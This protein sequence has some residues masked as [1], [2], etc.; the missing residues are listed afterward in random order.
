VVLRLKEL[1]PG[2]DGKVTPTIAN[3]VVTGLQFKTDEVD[4]VSPVRALTGLVKLECPGTFLKNGK[5][6]DLTPLR[7]LRLTHL[8]CEENPIADLSPLRGMPLTILTAGD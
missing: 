2:F 3:G 1:N 4:D 7:G 6:S 5:L 8:S